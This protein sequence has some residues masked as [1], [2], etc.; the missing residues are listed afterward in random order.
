V[1]KSGGM[2]WA[3]QVAYL[4]ERIDAYRVL[5]RKPEENRPLGKLRRRWKV[6]IKMNLK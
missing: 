6:N 4:R 5:V 2:R 1:N 3:G